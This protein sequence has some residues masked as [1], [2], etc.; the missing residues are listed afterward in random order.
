MTTLSLRWNETVGDSTRKRS[1][2]VTAVLW[3][4]QILSAA[5]FLFAGALKLTSA[6]L[7]VQEFGVIGL[8]QW[9]RYLTGGI[10]VASAV[11]LLIPALAAYGAA[12][13]AVT[14]VGAIITHL[15]VIG[16]S[17]AIPIVLLGATA[18]IA[19]VRGIGSTIERVTTSSRIFS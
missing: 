19:W 13:L 4:L 16:G 5:M 14:M 9:F 17:P 7:M 18:T 12:A 6:P 3:T 8:G 2:V 11:L 15:F 10:E 1:R